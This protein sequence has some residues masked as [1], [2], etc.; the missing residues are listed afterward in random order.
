MRFFDCIFTGTNIKVTLPNMKLSFLSIP[1]MILSFCVKGQ[2]FIPIII[3]TE[4]QSM[5]QCPSNDP[6]ALEYFKQGNENR[7]YNKPLAEVYYKGAI[8]QDSLFCDAYNNLSL[9]Y[10]KDQKYDS[11]WKYIEASLKINSSNPWA[12]ETKGQLLLKRKEYE[13]ATD[14]FYGLSKQQPGK[15]LWLYYIAESLFQQDLLDSAQFASLKMKFQM[16]NENSY[17]ADKYHYY[18]LGKIACKRG[19]YKTAQRTFP[20][21]SEEFSRDAEFNY[22]YGLSYLRMKKS[23]LKKA[24]KY[25]RKACNLGYEVSPEIKSELQ[26]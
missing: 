23:K 10:L 6:Q 7:R 19:D 4:N 12:L 16:A 15:S 11:A 5:Y 22:Y 20:Y 18:M 26:L 9:L 8:K 21:V 25:I 2:V 3:F 14:Y 17:M 24:R 1:L 13:E